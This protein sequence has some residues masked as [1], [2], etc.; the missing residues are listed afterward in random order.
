MTFAPLLLKSRAVSLPMPV[1]APAE[2]FVVTV[3]SKT[4]QH[5][6]LPDSE[7]HIPVITTVL[8]SSLA[9]LLEPFMGAIVWS[10]VLLHYL[11]QLTCMYRLTKSV[12]L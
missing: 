12:M 3:T 5:A 8:P 4:E 11:H 1:L 10:F 6:L 9:L 2:M 7:S